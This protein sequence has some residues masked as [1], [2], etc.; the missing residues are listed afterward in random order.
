MRIMK[1]IALLGALLAAGGAWAQNYP[2]KPVRVI[3]PFSAGGATDIV[4]RIVGQ[5][6]TDIWGQTVVVDDRAGAS[7]N[8]GGDLA[9][10][11]TPDGYTL[12]MTSGSIVTANQYLFKKMPFDP[13]KDLVAV[14]NV[15]S[16]PQAL[17]VNPGFPAKSVKE[18]IAMAKAK[19]KSMTFG[20]AGFGT[21]THLA[22]ENFI[23][24]A[25]IDAVHVPYKGEAP[26]ITDLV[27]GQIQFVT[28]NLAAAIAFVKQGKLR[29]LGVTS[30]TRSSQLPDVPAIAE[31]LPG[32]ENLGWFGFMVPAGTSKAIIEKVQKDTAKVLQSADVRKR[33]ADLGM[34]PVANSPAEFAKAIKEESARWAKIIRERKLQVN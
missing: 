8:I 34:A 16:G 7:G 27:G 31:T 18:L 33:L 9:A 17:V 28:P 19:P 12:F 26:A 24:S 21:Q 15:A 10:K 32:F 5:K 20:S 14:T 25:G 2:S 6:L 23:Y 1:W 3:V 30:K 11:S 29:A 4:A 13:E 22:A